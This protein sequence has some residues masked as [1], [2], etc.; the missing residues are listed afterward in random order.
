VDAMGNIGGGK[1]FV[2]ML[3]DVVRIRTGKSAI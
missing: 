2:S 1:V 3:D